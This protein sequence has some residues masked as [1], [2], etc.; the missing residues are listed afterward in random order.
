MPPEEDVFALI[1][2]I[3]WQPL[4]SVCPLVLTWL[5]ETRI[6]P[7]VRR[8]LV[9]PWN[10]RAARSPPPQSRKLRVLPGRP[11][12]AWHIPR[13]WPLCSMTDTLIGL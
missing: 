13:F 12:Q 8:T 7:G 4:N 10:A 5:S 6:A 11:N 1:K 9:A 2:V 3:Q